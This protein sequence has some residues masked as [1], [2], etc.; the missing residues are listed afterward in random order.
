MSDHDPRPEPG[1]P[2]TPAEGAGSNPTALGF[3][4]TATV[5]GC[6]SIVLLAPVFGTLGLVFGFLAFSQKEHILS[7]IGIVTALLGLATS[8]I[9]WGLLGLGTAV[10]AG[11]GG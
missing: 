4:I 5:C 2:E 9:L 10:T 8:P 6:I 3:G 7:T 11:G 1:I